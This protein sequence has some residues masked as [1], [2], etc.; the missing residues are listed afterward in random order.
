[1]WS[2]SHCLVGGAKNLHQNLHQKNKNIVIIIPTTTKKLMTNGV[3][4]IG[5]I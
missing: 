2:R 1:M 4:V 5:S 3:K